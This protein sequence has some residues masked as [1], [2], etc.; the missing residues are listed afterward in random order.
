MRVILLGTGGSAGVPLIGG[1][2]GSGN[3]GVCDA[4]EPRNRRT[5]GSIVE[6]QHSQINQGAVMGSGPQS[7]GPMGKERHHGHAQ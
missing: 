6:Q 2:D 5:R 3:W 1:A 7:L 4:A